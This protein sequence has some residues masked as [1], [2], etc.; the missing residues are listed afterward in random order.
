MTRSNAS[1]FKLREHPEI[2]VGE[3]LTY[4]NRNWAPIS[5]LCKPHGDQ[6]DLEASES[7]VVGRSEPDIC[8]VPAFIMRIRGIGDLGATLFDGKA[9]KMINSQLS[10]SH[11]R[12]DPW[13]FRGPQRPRLPGKGN[14]KPI[15]I[16]SRRRC[17]GLIV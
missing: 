3:S 4:Q 9:P 15:E 2:S 12:G 13:G 11:R 5:L 7:W 10:C 6:A 14:A 8:A 17:A 16:F 1:P